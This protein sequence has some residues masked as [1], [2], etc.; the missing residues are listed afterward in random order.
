MSMCIYVCIHISEYT[1]THTHTH[2]HTCIEI[3]S[4]F[5]TKK[6]HKQTRKNATCNL[7]IN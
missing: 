1:H 7:I 3:K 4:F 5:M 6:Y 2:T